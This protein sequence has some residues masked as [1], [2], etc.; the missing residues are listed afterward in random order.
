MANIIPIQ[1]LDA[2]E[3]AVYTRLTETQLR[4][5]IAPEK[6]L[7]IAESE[8]VIRVALNAGCEPVSMLMTERHLRNNALMLKERW[9]DIPIYTGSDALLSAMTG[10]T[11][12]RGML[13]AMRRPAP[14]RPEEILPS[15]R[16]AAVLEDIRDATNLG[17]V[18]RS[19]AAL[20]CGAVVLTPECAD[21]LNRRT[22]RVSMGTVLQVPWCRLEQWPGQGLALLRSLGFQTAALALRQNSLSLDD[23]R[24]K[25]CGKL[26][27]VLGTE[28]D[29][30]R[31]DT[32]AGCDYTVMIPMSNAVDS[33]NVAAAAAVSFYELCKE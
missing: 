10:Y 2:P 4:S 24:L 25:R 8:K 20:G 22:V 11:L 29:G 18:F 13:C 16:R 27:M 7:F 28:G 23:P 30:L 19:A 32:I 14:R 33:L 31:S 17:I 9:A 6:A 15:V 3:L 1:D 26:A 21:A 5:R 12:N